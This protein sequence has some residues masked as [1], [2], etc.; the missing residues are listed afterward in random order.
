MCGMQQIQVSATAQPALTGRVA[1]SKCRAWQVVDL[2]WSVHVC[3]DHLHGRL[4][5][6]IDA[7][8]SQ[9]DKLNYLGL[10]LA[11]GTTLPGKM[12]GLHQLRILRSN[13]RSMLL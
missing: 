13:A 11:A 2:P 4:Q 8:G 5:V 6:K 10:D 1:R 3:H 7:T 9:L 12:K